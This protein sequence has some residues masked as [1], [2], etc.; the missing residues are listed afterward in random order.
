MRSQLQDR[1]QVWGA[2]GRGDSKYKELEWGREL[3]LLE[4]VKR[5]PHS[6]SAFSRLLRPLVSSVTAAPGLS[7]ASLPPGW[8]SPSGV[9]PAPPPCVGCGLLWLP[10]DREDHPAKAGRGQN[11]LPPQKPVSSSRPSMNPKEP[12]AM[13]TETLS[14]PSRN[15]TVTRHCTQ[16][17]RLRNSTMTPAEA[18]LPRG[19]HP[20]LPFLPPSPA[21]SFPPSFSLTVSVSLSH[22]HPILCAV[23]KRGS[24]NRKSGGTS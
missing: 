10:G 6:P 17:Q 24:D 23:R 19:V 2:P 21:S 7:L 11:L 22:S 3:N 4:V 16:I 8:G 15:R 1:G 20:S 18:Q 5:A 13:S 9:L 12:T 14:V